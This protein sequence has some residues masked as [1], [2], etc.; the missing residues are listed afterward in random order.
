MWPK[1]RSR[2]D[3]I[4][5]VLCLSLAGTISCDD[6]TRVLPPAPGDPS[7]LVRALLDP[8]DAVQPILLKS[9]SPEVGWSQARVDLYLEGELAASVQVPEEMPTSELRPCFRRYTVRVGVSPLCPALD[10]SPDYG[11]SYRLIITAAGR[12]TA[13]A[14]GVIPGDFEIVSVSAGGD[15][16]GTEGLE[17]NWTRSEGS[18]RYVVG[19]RPDSIEGCFSTDPITPGC[20]RTWFAAT[21]DTFLRTKVPRS[22]LK[23]AIG[24]FYVDVF[25]IE[26]AL[27]EH[28]TTGA[29]G[30]YFS[31]PPVQNVRD[32]YGVVGSWVMR[33]VELD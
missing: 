1:F 11:A 19:I 18:W 12:P 30:E 2:R 22:G 9:V 31:V 26:R 28:L 33:T 16:P 4:T 21:E 29:G 13:S 23:G 17:V 24:R 27:Y 3:P 25:A 14:E 15:P 20:A 10:I 5:I 7:I 32:G 8:A 6:P